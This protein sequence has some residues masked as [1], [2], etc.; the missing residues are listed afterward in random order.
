MLSPSVIRPGVLREYPRPD[1]CV[2]ASIRSQ[3]EQIR[4]EIKEIG[5]EKRYLSA[6]RVMKTQAEALARNVGELIERH[7]RSGQ[8]E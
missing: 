2:L 6:L 4:D 1:I 7:E 8:G 3:S 5:D